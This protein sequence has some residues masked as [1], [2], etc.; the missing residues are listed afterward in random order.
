[1]INF[2]SFF[3]PSRIAEDKHLPRFLDVILQFAL[4][5][6]YSKKS[7]GFRKEMVASFHFLNP[8]SNKGN[9]SIS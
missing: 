2:I 8:P 6:S 1:M 3:F 5:L 4:Q 9:I 7:S